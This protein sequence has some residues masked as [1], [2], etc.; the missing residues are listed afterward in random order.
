M[1][2][3]PEQ[4][5]AGGTE[6]TG[7]VS[8]EE[9]V[10]DYENNRIKELLRFDKTLPVSTI[11]DFMRPKAGSQYAA[12]RE[13]V[14]RGDY[15][16]QSEL[17]FDPDCLKTVKK[18]YEMHCH[19]ALK[20]NADDGVESDPSVRTARK[21]HEQTQMQKGKETDAAGRGR[22]AEKQPEGERQQDEQQGPPMGDGVK[23]TAE[24]DTA[25][26]IPSG[27]RRESEAPVIS[28]GNAANDEMFPMAGDGSM[29]LDPNSLGYFDCALDA[30][31]GYEDMVNYDEL[32]VPGEGQLF[33]DQLADLGWD[34]SEFLD[35]R[36]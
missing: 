30:Y 36:P 27:A 5:T 9:E 10:E 32:G 11:E 35:L 7:L 3:D 34:N 16:D 19:K 15:S 26:D 28:C 2:E 18:E 20:V 31:G 6:E 1:P 23:A 25:A 12:V 14:Q 24:Q 21:R 17:L 22:A 8:T 13:A 4:A 29:C 33:T